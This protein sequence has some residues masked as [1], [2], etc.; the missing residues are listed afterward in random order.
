MTDLIKKVKT[1]KKKIGVYPIDEESWTDI[2]QWNE[3]KLAVEKLNN[4]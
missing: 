3:Y 4:S 1:L 2:G